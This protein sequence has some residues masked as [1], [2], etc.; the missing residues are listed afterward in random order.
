M[1]DS[2]KR[3]VV[4]VDCQL[5]VSPYSEFYAKVESLYND[6]ISEFGISKDKI[7]LEDFVSSHLNL[8]LISLVNS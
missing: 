4:D 6:F 1:S 5:V 3:I 2:K 8:F 7:S